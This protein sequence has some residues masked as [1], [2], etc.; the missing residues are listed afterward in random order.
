M[1]GR[2]M[3]GTEPQ[4]P[5]TGLVRSERN[6]WYSGAHSP[7]KKSGYLDGCLPPATW[8]MPRV[9]GGMSSRNVT[10]LDIIATA[11]AYGGI[12]TTGTANFAVN[13]GNAVVYPL[14]DSPPAR[15]ASASFVLSFANASGQL[16]S[17]GTGTAAMQFNFSN[18]LL[19]ASVGGT[20]NATL[21][22]NTNNALLGATAKATASASILIS[23][24]NAQA[25]PLND[26]SPVRTAS[27]SMIISIA[28][29]Q[30]YPL[31]DTSPARTASGSLNFSGSLT[32]YAVGSMQGN[33]VDTSILTS[34]SIAAAVWSAVAAEF[35][36]AGSTGNKLNTASSGGVDMQALVDAVL[37]D[38][39]FKKVLTTNKFIALK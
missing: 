36:E 2:R 28:N 4:L 6:N 18:A 22:I 35:N 11:I 30:A 26:T 13:F 19:T 14:N 33:T 39:R 1:L 16:I 37:D 15:T 31:N 38:P 29:A 32:P 21:V 10:E 24:A 3:A 25:Y 34:D 20:G 9:S 27:A 8:M 17:S 7:D 23:A 12:T 5:L